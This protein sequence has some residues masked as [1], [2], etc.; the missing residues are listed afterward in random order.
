TRCLSDWSSDVCSSDLG[1]SACGFDITLGGAGGVRRFNR[2]AAPGQAGMG[3]LAGG[4]WQKRRLGQSLGTA[5]AGTL[6]CEAPSST[7]VD[8]IGRASCRERV[9]VWRW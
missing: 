5:F 2:L 9:E 4:R 1:G 6:L 7:E 8:E 3:D